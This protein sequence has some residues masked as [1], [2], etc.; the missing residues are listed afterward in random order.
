MFDYDDGSMI[1][2][3]YVK[4]NVRPSHVTLHTTKKAV[5]LKDVLSGEKIPVYEV[6]F[7][8]DFDKVKEYVADVILAPGVF[9]MFKWETV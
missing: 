8:E 2:Y 6:G 9:R 5:V 4:G 7:N 1:L 3:K